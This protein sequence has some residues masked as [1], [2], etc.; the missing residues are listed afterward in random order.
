MKA[1]VYIASPYTIGDPVINL[2]KSLDAAEELVFHDY[3]PYCPL[4]CHLWHLASPKSY[5]FWLTYNMHWVKACDFVLRLPGESEG[6]DLEVRNAV[7]WGIP[8]FFTIGQ[9]LEHSRS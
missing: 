5:D 3:V 2:R 6:A 1:S 4:L 7:S 9:L 8:V